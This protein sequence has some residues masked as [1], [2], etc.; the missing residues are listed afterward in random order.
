MKLLYT[1]LFAVLS[2]SYMAAPAEL[3]ARQCDPVYYNCGSG[4][5]SGGPGDPPWP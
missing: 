5:G 4:G 1:L 2:V 3:E